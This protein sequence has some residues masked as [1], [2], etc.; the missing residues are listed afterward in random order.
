[1]T[2]HLVDIGHIDQI[3]LHLVEGKALKSQLG[4]E[5]V[6]PRVELHISRE[7]APVGKGQ[8]QARIGMVLTTNREIGHMDIHLIET[9]VA[10][11]PHIGV[12][13]LP[14]QQTDIVHAHHPVARRGVLVALDSVLL[15]MLD[16]AREIEM[17][18]VL[19]NPH[20]QARQG[21]V[22][23]IHRLAYQPQQRHPHIQRVESC[24]NV[25]AVVLIHRQI[26]HRHMT[27]E[28]IHPHTLHRGFAPQQFLA[29]AVDIILSHTTTEQRA[30]HNRQHNK[31]GTHRK[32]YKNDIQRLFHISNKD[33]Q[34]AKIQIK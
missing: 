4:I 23:H 25:S 27:G 26:P 13:Q 15:E 12:V 22:A 9:P 24:K 1:M 14:T 16:D 11:L 6:V 34:N 29:M 30:E 17:A 20:V 33:Y 2:L 10:V 31:R 3:R 32:N 8:R 5:M 21:D 18:S 19:H 7:R 28:Q